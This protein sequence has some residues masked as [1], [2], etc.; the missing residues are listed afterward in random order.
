MQAK[1]PIVNISLF[2][3]NKFRPFATGGEFLPRPPYILNPV[4]RRGLDPDL[5]DARQFD[6]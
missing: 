2:C 5:A 3:N 4:G 6:R 1:Q